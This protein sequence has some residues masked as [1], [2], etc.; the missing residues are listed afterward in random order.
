MTQDREA[1]GHPARGRTGH[2]PVRVSSRA[3]RAATPSDE[4]SLSR[5]QSYPPGESTGTRWCTGTRPMR[6]CSPPRA[7]SP[8]TT[9]RASATRPSPTGTSTH[10][11]STKDSS[12][13]AAVASALIELSGVLDLPDRDRYLQAAKRMLDELAS[14]AYLAAG[15]PSPAVLP[16]GV[17]DL[18]EG[19]AVDAGLIYGD[20]YFIEALARLRAAS[21]AGTDAG[22]VGGGPADAGGGVPS[23]PASSGGCASGSDAAIGALALLTCAPLRRR[24][25]RKPSTVVEKRDRS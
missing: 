20:Y 3:R 17:G 11:P 16:H 19:K 4:Q 6:A 25:R 8:T 23:S 15:T 14:P 12:A 18:P 24:L 1:P 22:P 7:R 10:P 21:P 5:V 9:S 13:A 2:L